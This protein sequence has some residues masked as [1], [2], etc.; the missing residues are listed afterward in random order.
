MAAFSCNQQ[1][2][3]LSQQM[4]IP[5]FCHARFCP[6]G[7]QRQLNRAHSKHQW[8]AAGRSGNGRVGS[9]PSFSD[10][11]KLPEEFK[12]CHVILTYFLYDFQTLMP[13]V[14]C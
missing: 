10:S 7:E 3:L 12:V 13:L 6:H 11:N 1:F 5:R 8:Q 9:T 14:L 2:R 4:T